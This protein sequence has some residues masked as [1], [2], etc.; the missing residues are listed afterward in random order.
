MQRILV[1]E[2]AQKNQQTLRL[3]QECALTD[4]GNLVSREVQLFA[5]TS[6]R[7]SLIVDLQIYDVSSSSASF[8]NSA[9]DGQYQ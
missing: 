6:L 4:F 3:C 8:F 7:H 9:S 2:I 5:K 1:A